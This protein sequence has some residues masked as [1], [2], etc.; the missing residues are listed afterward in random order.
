[1][2]AISDPRK[3]RTLAS[4]FFFL[5]SRNLSEHIHNLA[6]MLLWAVVWSLCELTVV[7]CVCVCASL[8]PLLTSAGLT[9][10]RVLGSCRCGGS[11][12]VNVC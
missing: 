8:P 10:S 7:F 1:M 4:D 6:D 9:G 3:P 5:C 11:Q 2:K 12:D